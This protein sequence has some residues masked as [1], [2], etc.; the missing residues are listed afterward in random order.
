[1][2][3]SRHDRII[4][5]QAERIEHRL[6]GVVIQQYQDAKAISTFSQKEK[7][8]HERFFFP[9]FANATVQ[10]LGCPLFFAVSHRCFIISY[11][12]GW[13]V[14]HFGTSQIMISVSIQTAETIKKNTGLSNYPRSFG[15]R[16]YGAA[17][18]A[19]VKTTSAGSTPCP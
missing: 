15:C 2:Q 5:L 19:P 11:C 18:K 8:F 4:R 10:V 7:E 12:V 17:T 13:D 1:M 16:A 14:R 3:K 6:D 9:C